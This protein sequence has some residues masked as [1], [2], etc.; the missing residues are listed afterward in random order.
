MVQIGIK[1]RIRN[2]Q[3]KSG[4]NLDIIGFLFGA[5]TN[6]LVAESLIKLVSN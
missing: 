5:C 4:F 2:D 3:V 1:T 6:I